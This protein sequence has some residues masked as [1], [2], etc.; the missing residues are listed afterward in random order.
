MADTQQP[1]LTLERFEALVAAY[2]GDFARYPERE[3]AGAEALVS[4]SREARRI[5]EAAHAL[6][7]LL[8]SA[9]AELPP[10]VE[11]E[12]RLGAI[13]H[14]YPQDRSVISML[15]FRSRGR[16]VLAAAAAVLLGM[17]GGR[18]VPADDDTGAQ[19]MT[20]QADMSALGFLDDL[21]ED[22]TLGEGGGLE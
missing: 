21:L 15:P 10:R 14:H 18:A 22:L 3:R 20:E 8:R 1:D 7:A 9:R 5:F 2:G 19:G 12:A 6:D 16:A 11:L 13:P 17:L 4:R